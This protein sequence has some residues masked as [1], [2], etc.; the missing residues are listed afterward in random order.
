LTQGYWKT[1]GPTGCATG[2]NTNEWDVTSLTLGSVSYT[3]LELCSIMNT[4]ASGNGLIA[5]AHQLIAA[6]LNI[7]NGSDPSAV[8]SDVAAADS[9]IGGLVIPPVGSGSLAPSVTS[10]LITALTNYNEGETGPGHCS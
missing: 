5:L 4:P 8:A 1:H 7:A 3:D 2:N 10:G 9:L 6:K